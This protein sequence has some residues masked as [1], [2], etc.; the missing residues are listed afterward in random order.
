MF[1]PQASRRSGGASVGCAET[2][3]NSCVKVPGVPVAGGCGAAATSGSGFC[4]EAFSVC[5]N[6][7]NSPALEGRGRCWR[8]RENGLLHHD[9]GKDICY[10]GRSFGSDV[11]RSM[12]RDGRSRGRR[13][14]CGS[15]VLHRPE[16]LRKF[17]GP[18]RRHDLWLQVWA[19][20]GLQVWAWP[21]E[22]MAA[23]GVAPGKS[24]LAASAMGVR[25][26]LRSH[27]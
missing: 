17:P 19:E 4:V 2:V 16:D 22:S 14:R 8:R 12:S 21:P 24:S 25:T 6:C 3:L 18:T 5:S 10:V 11:G 26:A 23:S 15:R 7:V 1:E 20:P 13:W 27:E 9:L